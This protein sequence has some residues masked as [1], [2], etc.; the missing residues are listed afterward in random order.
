MGPQ[1][2][3]Q[4]SRL[5]M[6]TKAAEFQEVLPAHN[7]SPGRIC[8]GTSSE[9]SYPLHKIH[10]ISRTAILRAKERF[11]QASNNLGPVP[12]KQVHSVR[13]VP[14]ANYFA[15]TDPSTPGGI[16]RLY[17]SYRR[18]LASSN[19]AS[20]LP[21]PWFQPGK[22]G[23]HIQ[24]YA[25]RAQCSS[26]DFHKTHRG[27]CSSTQKQGSP[28][29]GVPRRLAS[30]GCNEDSMPSSSSAGH[31]VSAISGLP[32]Q[33]QEV[34]ISSCS[35][36]PMARSPL[37]FKISQAVSSSSQEEGNCKV[38]QVS[39]SVDINYQTS[40]RKSLGVPSVCSGYGPYLES[41]T[42][43]CQQS[44]EKKGIQRSKRSS[45]QDSGFTVQTTQA[46]VH[47]QRSSE[48]NASALSA[49]V[50]NYS[51]GCV[52]T[53]LG[54][55]HSHQISAGSMVNEVSTISHQHSR[56]YGSVSF[57]EEVEPQEGLPYQIS[58]RQQ[59]NSLLYQQTGFKISA[60]QS[61]DAG[62]SRFSDKKKM[63]SFSSSFGRSP[64]RD[65]GCFVQIQASGN[66]MVP[67]RKI[68][69]F[70]SGASP[71]TAD[72]SVCNEQ[73]QEASPLCSTE[74][75]SGSSGDG[76]DVAGLEPVDSHLFVSSVQSSVESFGQTSNLQGD[77]CSSG[78]QVA[79]K[80]LVPSCSGVGSSSDSSAGPSVVSGCSAG[81]CLRFLLDN[82]EPSAHDF[83]VLASK[84]KFDVQKDKI[85]FIENYKS[86]TTRRQYQASW[87]KWVSYIQEHKPTTITMDFCLAFFI[88]LHEEGL[89]SKTISSYKSAL[90]RPV[91][92]AFGINFNSDL[93]N[94][95]TRACAR[96]KPDAPPKPISWSLDKV[97]HFAS[98]IDNESASLKD[99]TQKSIF[100]IAMASGARVSEIVALSRDD[101]H[102]EFLDSGE[103][104]LYPDPSFLA[105]NELPTKRWGPWKIVPLR[106]DLSLCPIECLKAFLSKT[107]F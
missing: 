1:H 52:G 85:D 40:S 62:Y 81:D 87:K 73:Q 15:D 11:E 102:I 9:E 61:C 24:S 64:Q 88:S 17:R 63:A 4:R 51:H 5:E 66:R 89:A 42:Q 72:R 21:L 14:N 105:K 65:R 54:G 104:N 79:Q 55:S 26:K 70:H 32:D 18:L 45:P 49:S 30:V 86:F 84:S 92:Y 35:R 43:R 27:S 95:L 56:S 16:H 2:S 19:R 25:L 13:Q 107:G 20:L 90:T 3:L 53:R 91:E 103:V 76:C 97:L 39:D 78:S 57:S 31:E 10:E 47:C 44:M 38:R 83:L 33:L 93:F 67:R 41:K 106:E 75:G 29:H 80:Q 68:I 71:G 36:I 74:F 101:G 8:S 69:L 7:T 28:G 100:L 46:V 60:D 37:G 82:K 50:S 77:G 23:L 6:E 34:Q 94:K 22:K 98:S 96:L 48:S 12:T 59:D 58:P 99:I